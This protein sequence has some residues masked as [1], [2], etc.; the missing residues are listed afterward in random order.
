MFEN[1]TYAEHL[2]QSSY[3]IQM[4]PIKQ[5]CF[6]STNYYG[7]IK[8]ASLNASST[9]LCLIQI[10]NIWFQN[11]WRKVIKF[12]YLQGLQAHPTDSHYWIKSVR[13][14][15]SICLRRCVKTCATISSVSSW[16]PSSDWVFLVS[17]AM[18]RKRRRF[19]VS[20]V[21]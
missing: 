11:T 3:S 8:C 16:R 18:E 20:V 4:K 10:T 5:Y 17:E 9:L 1:L 14:R 7:V 15:E 19:C 6:K 2:S 12:N 21:H 13:G